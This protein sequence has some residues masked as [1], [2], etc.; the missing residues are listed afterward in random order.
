L[1][2][3]G[4]LGGLAR[5]A[6]VSAR[7]FP[8][9]G[10]VGA[11][12]L[13]ASWALDWGLSGRRTLWLFFP[14]WFGYCLVVEGLVEARTGSSLL[15]RSG[16]GYALLFVVSVALW[17]S[18]EGLNR[19]L[20][21][22]AYLGTG[23][24]PPVPLAI[25]ESVAFSTVVPAV[26]STTEWFGSL[27]GLGGGATDGDGLRVGTDGDGPPVGTAT[28]DGPRLHKVGAWASVVLGALLLALALAVPTRFFPAAWL[29]LIP[30]LE[31]ANVALGERSL[32]W[33]AARRGWRAVAAVGLA[34][35]QCGLLWELWNWRSYPKWAYQLPHFNSA[36]LFAMPLL[37]YLGYPFFAAEVVVFAGLV[38]ALVGRWRP[39]WRRYL[40]EIPPFHEAASPAG[41]GSRA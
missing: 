23:T 32:T 17:W 25:L 34:G 5:F 26:I 30:L 10:W 11:L 28:G 20:G 41:P 27:L 4:L 35:I 13:T 14:L 7:R 6:P 8:A 24:F 36:H 15:R 38:G 16:G 31:P 29:F 12:L 18:F 37:G 9:V 33:W 22:W 2:P 39:R 40:P 3:R 19:R 1:R 21:D